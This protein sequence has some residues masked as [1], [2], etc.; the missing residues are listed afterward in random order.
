MIPAPVQ[1]ADLKLVI[2]VCILIYL[3]IV[4]YRDGGSGGWGG[5]GLYT[6]FGRI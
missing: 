2:D 5:G 3:M 6:D 4:K 1:C